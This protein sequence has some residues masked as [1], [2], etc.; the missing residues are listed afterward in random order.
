MKPKLKNK[1]KRFIT[2]M[3]KKLTSLKVLK[4]LNSEKEPSNLRST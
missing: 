1:S 3:R 4:L 2:R